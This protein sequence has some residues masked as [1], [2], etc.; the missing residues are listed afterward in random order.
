MSHSKIKVGGQSPNT[1]GEISVTLNNL[2]NVSAGSPSN[3]EVL[4]YS[5]GSW[6]NSTISSSSATVQFLY[7]GEGASNNYFNSGLTTI[8]AN[9]ELRLY[10]SSPTNTITGATITK[11]GSTDWI[12]FVTLPAGEYLIIAQVRVNF[13]G[14]GYFAYQVVSDPTGSFTNLTPYAVIGEN[15]DSHAQ[16]VSQTLQGHIELT[17]S[18]EIGFNIVAVQ[19]VEPVV[20][21]DEQGN[22]TYPQGDII[23]EFSY[24]F[25]EK[26][27]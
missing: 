20:F 23:S 6:I 18:T 22:V 21:E 2:S 1:S 26:L 16:G 4:K 15:A 9:D 5:S 19:N 27:S 10:D 12:K 24:M 13:I 11:E 17:S 14:S 3:D 25:I 8:G 7:I